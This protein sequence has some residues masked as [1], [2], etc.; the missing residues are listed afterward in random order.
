MICRHCFLADYIDP[1]FHEMSMCPLCGA[2]IP[3]LPTVNPLLLL[4]VSANR[5]IALFSI[6]KLRV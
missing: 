6:N 1:R 5:L 4:F 2:E 3:L